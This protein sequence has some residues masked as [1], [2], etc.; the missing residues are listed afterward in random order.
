MNK[1]VTILLIVLLFLM[2]TMIGGCASTMGNSQITN[3]DEVSKIVVGKSTKSDIEEIFGE[4]T[5]TSFTD[6]S[7]VWTYNYIRTA[8]RATTFIPIVSLFASGGDTENHTLMILFNKNGIVTRIGRDAK[9]IASTL[10]PLGPLGGVHNTIEDTSKTDYIN[11]IALENVHMSDAA[12]GGNMAVFGEIRN[13]G[14]KILKTVEITI[15]CLG[16]DGQI[17]YTTKNHPVWSISKYEVVNTP[18]NSGESRKFGIKLKD[19]P[20]DWD[21]KVDIKVTSIEF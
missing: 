7:E 17:I 13:D 15:N 3:N 9:N 1:I 18:L 8:L 14:N 11:F 12:A 10:S 16:Q 19:M 5:T 2:I 21:K 4:P 20:S 6:T